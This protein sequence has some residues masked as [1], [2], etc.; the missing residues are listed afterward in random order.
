[1][2]DL[3]KPLAS[4]LSLRVAPRVIRAGARLHLALLRR[5]PR[6]SVI[7]GDTL[8][9]TT[10]GRTTGQPRATPLYYASRGERV[11][12]AASFAGRDIPPNWYLNLLA[13][14]Q[15]VVE[16]S[17][18]RTD[19]RARVLSQREA[20]GVWPLLLSVYRPYARYRR[21]AHREIPVIELARPVSAPPAG[22][23]TAGPG[24]VVPELLP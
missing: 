13:D 4:L 3:S 24:T 2:K 18:T 1:M 15:V 16:I 23:D 20:E 11:Y 22:P 12:V 14:P 19:C 10:R 17:G 5:F 7:G 6:A 8:V 21:R 9:L